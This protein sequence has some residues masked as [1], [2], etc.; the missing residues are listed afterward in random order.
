[1]T[2][3]CNASGM[4][5]TPALASMFAALPAAMRNEFSPCNAFGMNGIPAIATFTGFVGSCGKLTSQTMEEG[6]SSPPGG[7]TTER[8]PFRAGKLP[9]ADIVDTDR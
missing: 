5:G 4:R 8:D 1:M 9:W 6:A 2:P 3:L 7:Y